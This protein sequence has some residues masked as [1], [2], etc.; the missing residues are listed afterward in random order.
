MPAG[1]SARFIR[2]FVE[3]LE[4]CHGWVL[5][6]PPA[7]KRRPPYAAPSLLLVQPG[8]DGLLSPDSPTLKL[9]A[10][11]LNISRCFGSPVCWSRPWPT[12]CKCFWRDQ[13]SGYRLFTAGLSNKRCNWPC[14]LQRW[15][16]LQM[17]DWHKIQAA[18]A[19]PRAGAR[20]TCEKPLAPARG[21]G[22]LGR[23]RRPSPRRKRRR[24]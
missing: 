21:R 3:Q 18:Q 13:L 22:A 23:H 9:E 1:S 8:R 5:P 7:R 14:A 24:G 20:N 16:T 12:V 19:A 6:S 10:A 17:L 2:E 11:C 15:A 4:P